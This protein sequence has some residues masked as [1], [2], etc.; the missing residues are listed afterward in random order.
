M[1]LRTSGR[2]QLHRLQHGT[3]LLKA[4]W[5][6]GMYRLQ[7]VLG[8]WPARGLPGSACRSGTG[9]A[10]CDGALGAAYIE[11]F[12]NFVVV[13]GILPAETLQAACKL[14][15]APRC[16]PVPMVLRQQVHGF[17]EALHQLERLSKC[18]LLPQRRSKVFALRAIGWSEPKIGVGVRPEFDKAEETVQLVC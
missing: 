18:Q 15:E 8:C 7:S 17:V 4:L 16:F 5:P 11:L 10:P 14:D 1:R 3:N 2:L 12:V 6:R 9:R 13:T